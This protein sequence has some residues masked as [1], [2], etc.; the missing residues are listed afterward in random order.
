MTLVEYAKREGEWPSVAQF[1]ISDLTLKLT[2]KPKAMLT[3]NW[4]VLIFLI[5]YLYFTT[6]AGLKK[7]R[8]PTLFHVIIS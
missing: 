6:Q 4:V 3:S 8:R 5:D 1:W 7:E 2:P